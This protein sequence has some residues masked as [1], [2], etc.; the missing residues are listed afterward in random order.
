M[1]E[2]S[3]FGF[4]DRPNQTDPTYDPGYAMPCPICMTSLSKPTR[5]I[6]LMLPGDSRCFFYRMHRKCAEET[7][8]E[9]INRIESALI[10]Q[11]ILTQAKDTAR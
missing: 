1:S 3:I 4:F 10:D 7:S 5:T 9:E 11:R 6:S 2:Q 8:K